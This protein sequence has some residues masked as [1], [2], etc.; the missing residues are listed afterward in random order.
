M[1]KQNVVSID[2][3]ETPARFADLLNG[4]VYHGRE[5]V[6]AA[7]IRELNSSVSR[8]SKKKKSWQLMYK[9]TVMRLRIFVKM[10]MI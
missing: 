7:D 1:Q 3:L 4:Y 10:P 9:S 2:Y 6:D 5:V 8:I